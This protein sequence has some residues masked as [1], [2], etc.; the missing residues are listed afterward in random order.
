MAQWRKSHS[1]AQLADCCE[2]CW[3]SLWNNWWVEEWS[4]NSVGHAMMSYMSKCRWWKRWFATCPAAM[5]KC[6]RYW[7]WAK[8]E[9]STLEWNRKWNPNEDMQS[10]RWRWRKHVPM[11]VRKM[12]PRSVA[13]KAFFFC[14]S[15]ECK[16]FPDYDHTLVGQ[17]LARCY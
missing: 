12:T 10:W 1:I 4:I 5:E 17:S 6:R 2:W 14:P 9:S 11:I 7:T 15:L 3:L 16:S 13:E 8:R